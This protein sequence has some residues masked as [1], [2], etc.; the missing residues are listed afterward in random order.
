[1]FFF[2]GLNKLLG[3][4]G[5]FVT[6][7]EER[8]TDS[9][10]M[11]LVTPFASALPFIELLLGVLLIVGLF[12]RWALAGAG[13]LMIGLT[14][15]AVMEP[16]PPTVANNVLFAVVIFGLLMLIQHDRYSLDARREPQGRPVE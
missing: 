13:L 10:P 16:D 12:S 11:W 4:V 7:L 9:L 2:Y 6:G 1:M 15:G 8:F 5:T 14:F 3:G